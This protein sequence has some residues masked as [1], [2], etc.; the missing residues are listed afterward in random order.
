MAGL[1]ATPL[2][3]YFDG[4]Q[5]VLFLRDTLAPYLRSV[6]DFYTSYATP[7]NNTHH[8]HDH[9]TGDWSFDLL[10]TCAQ[11]TCN[12]GART[13]S[14]AKA[15]EHNNH[16]DLAYARMAYQRLL[17][18]T[19]PLP[20]LH[21]PHRPRPLV[22]ATDQERH[23]WADML[24]GL[25]PFPT[26]VTADNHTVFAQVGTVVLHAHIDHCLCENAP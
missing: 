18:Y 7:H 17:E 15:A 14:G 16:Q 22:P 8:L 11:E 23:Q 25:A 6:A 4:T 3:A 19:D 21:H 26:A 9:L 13:A 24:R 1:V 20:P 10:W 5:D 12:G 2:V